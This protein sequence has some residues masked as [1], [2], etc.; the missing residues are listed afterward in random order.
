[1]FG[2]ILRFSVGAKGALFI[3]VMIFFLNI[4]H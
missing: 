3:L 4:R 2:F 1:M